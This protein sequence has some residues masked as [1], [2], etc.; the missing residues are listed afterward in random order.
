M[1]NERLQRK[2]LL[3]YAQC[4]CY[5]A[6]K[7]KTKRSTVLRMARIE[8][9]QMKRKREQKVVDIWRPVYYYSNRCEQLFETKRRTD[10]W[11]IV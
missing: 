1:Y 5:N 7:E 9:L 11:Q 3:A 8:L 2:I 4:V 6:V 10:L